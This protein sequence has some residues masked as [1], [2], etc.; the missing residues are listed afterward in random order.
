[1]EDFIESNC[2]FLMMKN[3]WSGL[4]IDGS[5]KNISW[6]RNS[7]Y[8]WKHDLKT[9]CAFIDRENKND[10]LAC[11]DFDY[12][13]GVLS[14]DLDGNDYFVL[15]AIKNWRPRILVCEFN[16]IF[17]PSRKLSIPYDPSFLRFKHH[18]SGLYWGL[19]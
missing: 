14:I 17:G 16:P 12:D 5:A 11:S 9:I 8:F 2:R 3:N 1:M 15:S 4:I 10:L 7:Y 13:L 6:L 19:L 18:P